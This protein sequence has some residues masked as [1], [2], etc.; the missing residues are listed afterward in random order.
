[1]ELRYLGVILQGLSATADAPTVNLAIQLKA[2]FS[3]V[4]NDDDSTTHTF[5]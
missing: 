1:M 3:K 4:F 5:A 2:P